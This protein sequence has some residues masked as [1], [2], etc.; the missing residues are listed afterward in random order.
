MADKH[1]PAEQ[2]FNQLFGDEPGVLHAGMQRLRTD[3]A[4]T[5]IFKLVEKGAEGLISEY[6]LSPS[7]ARKL[8]RPLNSMA[9]YVLRQ[10]IERTARGGEQPNTGPSSGLLSIVNGPNLNWLLNPRFQD[11]CPADALESLVSPAAYLSYLLLWI[12]DQIEKIAGADN[13]PLHGRRPDLMKLAIDSRT[14]FQRVS[15]VEISASVLEKFITSQVPTDT[16]LEN[17][18]ITARYPN[19]LPYDRHW[20]TIDG[21]V[22]LH[23]LSVGDLVRAIDVKSPY[24]LGLHNWVAP[25]GAAWAH[26]TG[27]GPYQRLLLTEPFEEFDEDSVEKFYCA[28]F[29]TLNLEHLNLNQVE[30][31]CERTKLDTSTIKDLL[32]LGPFAPVRS[33][34]VL[35][36]TDSDEYPESARS[37]SVYINAGDHPGIRFTNAANEQFQ[38]ITPDPSKKEGLHSYDRMNRKL[39]LDKWFKLSSGE[40]DEILVALILAEQRGATG[41]NTWAITEN[42]THGLGL[43]Q[44]LR[45]RYNCS[46]ADFA[47][48]L[49]GCSIYGRGEALSQFDQIFNSQG[50]QR[51]SFKLDNLAFQLLPEPGS[52]D[53]TVSQLCSGLGIDLQTYHYLALVVAGAQQPSGTLSRSRAIISSF[54]R[55]V[56]LARMF[57]ITPIEGISL[58]SLLGGERG[59]IGLAGEPRINPKGKDPDALYL[60]EAMDAC[61][62]WCKQSDMSVLWM[63][64]HAAPL[65]PVSE[66]SDR[67][68]QFFE[69]IRGLLPA[70][71]FSNI[72]LLMA[73]VPPAGADSWLDFLAVEA[74]GLKPLIDADGLVL[75]PEGTAEQYRVFVLKKL[76]WAI[77]AVFVDLTPAEL[78]PMLQRMLA[79][80]EQA[81]E[82]Q[83]S[84]VQETLAVYAA[85]QVEQ[86]VL[87]LNWAGATVYQLLRQIN[88]LPGADAQPSLRARIAS[89]L[90]LLD[91]LAE[92]RRRSE[93]VTK[94][95]LSA[96]LLQDYLDYGYRTWFVQDPSVFSLSTLYYLTVLTRAFGMSEQPEQMLL[97]YLREVNELPPEMTASAL[98]LARKAA[99]IKLAQYFD[100]SVQDVNE[101]VLHI[102]PAKEVLKKLDQLDALMRIRTLS[103][104]TGMDAKTILLIGKLP[105]KDVSTAY[106]TA[107]EFALLSATEARSPLVQGGGDLDQLLDITCVPDRQSVIANKPGEKAIYTVKVTDT[108]KNPIVGMPIN[109]LATLGHIQSAQTDTTGTMTATFTPGA[110]LGRETPRYWPTMFQPRNAPSIDI[111]ADLATM[112]PDDK[113]PTPHG[114]V[115]LGQEVELNITLSDDWGNLGK[116]LPVEWDWK[117]VPE[118]DTTSTAT[119]RISH[120]F[121]NQEGLSRAFVTSMAGGTFVFSVKS[122]CNNIHAYFEAITFKDKDSLP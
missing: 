103:I 45:T 34:N 42:V 29:G 38:R 55:L 39:R 98:K 26:D 65:Q 106:A 115:P 116:N 58:L 9:T 22:R 69:Q 4:H 119:I 121:T 96:G 75:A 11:K 32:S 95:G 23:G 108:D 92:V 66:A 62:Q 111:G 10:Y 24:F 72:A 70:A 94:L 5:P 100:W 44:T 93:V 104:E 101:C 53:L 113:S 107:A 120:E 21:V 13:K 15:S 41:A 91:L 52:A 99:D 7:D 57:G 54:Y 87:T 80:F 118:T 50:S 2:M 68:L 77:K 27:L 102:V 60:I 61:V 17:E 64:Q 46:A 30:F 43:F 74:D 31:F 83:A 37:H 97:D 8:M 18:L 82:A 71:L 76:E 112:A 59:L 89:S 20:E 49:D 36:V 84:V 19:G 79:V 109:W 73:G 16:D 114:D 67:E 1:R 51:A 105:E 117:A 35:Y 40:V 28:N 3:L 14:T 81:S 122:K 33:A 25:S 86:A 56:T 48:F 47:V 88:D 12:R 63:L 78:E 6:E 110:V 85:I 90:S